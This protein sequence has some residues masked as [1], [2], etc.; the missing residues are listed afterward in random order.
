MLHTLHAHSLNLVLVDCAKSITQVS[1]FFSLLQSLYI[2]MSFSK[3]HTLFINSQ[4]ELH[5]KQQTRELQKLCETRW[6]CKFNSLDAVCRTFDSIILTL[7]SIIY[8]GDKAKAIE[9]A[10]LYHHVHS[11][12]FISFLII[13]VNLCLL[14]FTYL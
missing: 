9:A 12:S 1:E 13:R 4:L 11:F 5:P 10:G 2:F 3:A 7:Q 6:A 8:D 14:L